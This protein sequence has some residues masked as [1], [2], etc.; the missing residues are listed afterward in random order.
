M[1]DATPF[2]LPSESQ[3]VAVST[4]A[5]EGGYEVKAVAKAMEGQ[6]EK[7]QSQQPL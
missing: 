5:L 6:S 2:L 3:D 4:L 7:K 1:Q